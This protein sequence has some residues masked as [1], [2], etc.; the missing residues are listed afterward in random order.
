MW[1]FCYFNIIE[2][3]KLF[4]LLILREKGDLAMRQLISLIG[5][6]CVMLL[7][8]TGYASIVTFNSEAAFLAS[9]G[10][11]TFQSFETLP[12]SD[13]S[14]DLLS[15]VSTPDFDVSTSEQFM[16]IWGDPPVSFAPHGDQLLF[17]YAQTGGSITFN[18]FGGGIYSFGLFITD[19]ATSDPSG[20]TF[21][22][23]FE[24]NIGDTHTIAS[25]TTRL[26]DY[27]EIFFGVVSDTPFTSVTL[28]TSSNDGWVFFDKVYTDSS[29]IPV[30]STILL[31]WI[32]LLGLTG[33]TRR[34]R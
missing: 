31:L 13:T 7:S 23:L 15:L 29:P 14:T 16:Q 20:Q 25:T 3:V 8:A 1:H 12:P 9:S 10:S 5:V 18:N 27:N 2:L 22:L 24:N 30:P 33:I 11:V 28:T 19:W 17:W 6:L 32:G 26:P 34:K 4:Y 21:D